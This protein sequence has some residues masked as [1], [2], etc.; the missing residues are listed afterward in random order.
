[1]TYPGPAYDH[2]DSDRG[3]LPAMRGIFF[4]V[5]L[6]TPFWAAVAYWLLS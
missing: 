3:Q 2:A 4:S 1:M 6:C 5:I